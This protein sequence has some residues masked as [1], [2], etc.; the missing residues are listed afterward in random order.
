M[1]LHDNDAKCRRRIGVDGRGLVL[2]MTIGDE[3]MVD[4]MSVMSER[5]VCEIFIS[6]KIIDVILI[7]ID[8]NLV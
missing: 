8:A 3:I 2:Y 4:M 6:L 5:V 7:E 1:E